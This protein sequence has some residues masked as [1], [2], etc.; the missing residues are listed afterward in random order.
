MIDI[1]IFVTILVFMWKGYD[2]EFEREFPRLMSL[3]GAVIFGIIFYKVIGML[4]NLTP[5]NEIIGNFT[6]DAFLEKISGKE[7]DSNTVN[8]IFGAITHEENKKE[9]IGEFIVKFIAFI[10]LFVLA[11]II[12]RKILRK[13]Q[14]LNKIKVVRQIR[15]ALGGLVGFLRGILFVYIAVGFLVVCEPLIPTEVIRTQVEKSEI[16][17]V[18]YENNYIANIVAQHDYLSSGEQ[19]D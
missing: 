7:V 13:K 15:P 10:M 3:I 6:T 5:L 1:I 11:Y 19:E 14:L 17:R 2:R 9:L 12:I 16:G 18:M 8:Q 4:L